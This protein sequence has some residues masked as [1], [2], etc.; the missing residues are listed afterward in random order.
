[1]P[2]FLMRAGQKVCEPYTSKHEERVRSEVPAGALNDSPF[3][4]IAASVS[5]V[6]ECLGVERAPFTS[7]CVLAIFVGVW[8]EGE[9]KLLLANVQYFRHWN[10][11]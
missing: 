6:S 2:S 8:W 5:K 11:R 3:S 9:S 1:M 10:K 4:G 7:L